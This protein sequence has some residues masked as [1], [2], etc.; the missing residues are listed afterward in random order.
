MRKGFSWPQL[1]LDFEEY[2][3]PSFYLWK[4]PSD[5]GPY[6]NEGYTFHRTGHMNI[7]LALLLCWRVQEKKQLRLHFRV[8]P[9]WYLDMST[10]KGFMSHILFSVSLPKFF[11][12]LV[13]ILVTTVGISLFTVGRLWVG[14]SL[15]LFLTPPIRNSYRLTRQKHMYWS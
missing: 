8:R 2:H 15:L 11:N 10:W 6:G 7:P 14:W 12:H 13:G 3:K 9:S 5:S 4:E 1:S